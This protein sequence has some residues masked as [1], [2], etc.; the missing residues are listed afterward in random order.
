MCNLVCICLV[1]GGGGGHRGDLQCADVNKVPR[2]SNAEEATTTTTTT[3]SSK[4]PREEVS[5][6]FG[7][8]NSV[9]KVLIVIPRRWRIGNEVV[10]N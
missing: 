8:I 7:F 3:P 2:T 1:L 10:N 9:G 6:T 5:N 4:N